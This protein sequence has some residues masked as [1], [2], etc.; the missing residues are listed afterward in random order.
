MLNFL[1]KNKKAKINVFAPADG[2]VIPITLVSDELFSSKTLGDGYAVKPITDQVYAPVT[3]KITSIFPT[4]HA[5]SF[6]SD[7]GLE[8]LMHMGVD[9]VEL[10]GSPFNLVIHAGQRIKA[11]TFLGTIDRKMIIDS[12]R[13]DEMIVICTSIDNGRMSKIVSKS[14]KHGETVGSLI[15]D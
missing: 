8:W 7:N 9:T 3:G 10:K 5:I 6:K 11:G 13:S 14:V 12:G 15:L 4:K 2:K 1:K